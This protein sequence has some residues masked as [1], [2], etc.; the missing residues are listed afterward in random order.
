MKRVAV[1]D[2]WYKTLMIISHKHKFIFVKTRKTASTSTECALSAICGPDDILT[3]LDDFEQHRIGSLGTQ[4][5][6]YMPPLFSPEWPNL[7]SRF[8]RNGKAPFDYYNHINAWRIE[9]RLSKT[10]WNSY[11]KFAFDRNPWDREV[12]WYSHLL[13]QTRTQKSFTE[14][15]HDLPKDKVRNFEIYSIHGKV[16]VDFIGKFEN[17]AADLQNIMDEVGVKDQLHIPLTRQELRKDRRP[18]S[19]LYTPEMRDIIAGVYPQ[20][21]KLLGYEF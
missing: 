21:I 2:I 17:L 8:V 13:S 12:S 9:K 20:E 11:F 10:V 14:H 16:A 15:V 3:A 5:C 7:I 18:Y 4:N 1:A 19:E 6:R